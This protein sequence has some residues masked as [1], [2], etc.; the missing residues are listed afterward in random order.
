MYACSCKQGRKE[1]ERIFNKISR[2]TEKRKRKFFIIII[3]STLYSHFNTEIA[4]C[5]KRAKLNNNNN[6]NDKFKKK[7]QEAQIFF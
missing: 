6:N 7:I 1:R 2:G 4:Q 5:E 3:I